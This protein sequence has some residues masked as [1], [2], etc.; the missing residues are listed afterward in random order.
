MFSTS[1]GETRDARHSVRG[2]RAIVIALRARF[3][4]NANRIHAESPSACVETENPNHAAMQAR[5][6]RESQRRI[7]D[8][9]FVAN[10]CVT[11]S[12]FHRGK[13]AP[14]A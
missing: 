7:I 1:A 5:A 13:I 11:A 3:A 12:S 6:T 8:A 14:T 9:L 2:G 10:P 4:S